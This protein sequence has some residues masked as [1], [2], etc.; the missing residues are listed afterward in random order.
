MVRVL[1]EPS[2]P[3]AVKSQQL[4]KA[5]GIAECF[6]V[7]TD[8]PLRFR[9]RRLLSPEYIRPKPSVDDLFVFLQRVFTQTEASMKKSSIELIRGVKILKQAQQRGTIKTCQGSLHIRPCRLRFRRSFAHTQ[10]QILL[11]RQLRVEG[12]LE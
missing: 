4:C 1:T 2:G 7:F 12:S 11:V 9:Y 10:V 6:P 5:H 3:L 8:R